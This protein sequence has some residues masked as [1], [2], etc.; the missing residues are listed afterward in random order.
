MVDVQGFR[1]D[2]KNLDVFL[3]QATVSV[4]LGEDM[5]LHTGIKRIKVPGYKR[6]HNLKHD[7]ILKN[8]KVF[9]DLEVRFSDRKAIL[10]GPAYAYEL[11]AFGGGVSYR[12]S[13]KDLGYTIQLGASARY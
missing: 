3:P 5:Y 13:G 2:N 8:S 12:V 4:S 7:S 10:V 1:T 6:Q 9:S 11:K